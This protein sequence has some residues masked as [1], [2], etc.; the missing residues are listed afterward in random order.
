MRCLRSIRLW[1]AMFAGATAATGSAQ[2]TDYDIIVSGGTAP[3]EISW[4]LV[5]AFGN[6][7]TQG[8]APEN[9]GQ[10]LDD[11]CYTMYMYDD[12]GD[13]WNGATWSINFENTTISIASGTLTDGGWGAIQI[14]IGGVGCGGSG[15]TDQQI[16]VTAGTAPLDVYWEIYDQFN[17]FVWSGSAPE[18]IT[19]CLADGCYSMYLYDLTGDGWNGAEY[20]ITDVG[21]GTVQATGTL[22]SGGFATAQIIIGAGCGAC[23][24]YTMNVT[25]GSAPA[26]VSWEL[27]DASFT[28]I[29]AG[30]A[31]ENLSLC[32]PPGCYTIYMYDLIG[33][34]WNGA[35]YTFVN[36]A[37][38]TTEASGTLVNGSF[39]T[40]QVSIGGGC[41]SPTCSNFTMAVTGGSAPAQVSWNFMSM[42][43]NYGSGGAPNSVQMC[44]DTGCY[45]MQMYDAASN[46]W[47]GATWT[48]TNSLGATVGSGTLASGA[49]GSAAVNLGTGPCTVPTTVTASD[50]PQAVNVCTNLNFTIDPSGWGALW[51]IPALGSTGNPEFYVGDGIFS[52][53]GT[54]HYGC[55][56]GQEINTTWMIVN[57]SGSGSLEFTLGANGSQ[58]GF[59]DWTMFPYNATT[60][61]AIMANSLAPVRCNWNYASYGGTGLASTIPSGG[62]PENYETP[63]NVLAGQR[64]I[65]CFS[66]W[67]SVTTVVPLVF[68]GT[69]TVSCTPIVLPVELID[70]HA[71]PGPWSVELDW[72]TATE[73]NTSRFDVQRSADRLHW[74]TIGSVPASGNSASAISYR[75]SDPHPYEGDTYYRLAMIDQDAS[76]RLTP[77]VMA[78]WE[79]PMLHCWP[80]PTSGSF[81]IDLGERID[82]A[83]VQLMDHLGRAVSVHTCRSGDD[84]LL[85][86]MGDL[87]EGTYW[88]R[89][90]D[91]T[92]ERT[93]RIVRTRS[94]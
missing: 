17:N 10:C 56:M 57:I 6:T 4:E 18:N 52:P 36:D 41:S 1:L 44:L 7:V 39:G 33:N 29:A 53:W 24:G 5:D 79:A 75:L 14:D 89:V 72:T 82:R 3:D 34:G 25:S 78:H 42:G 26:D 59:Y 73:H 45:V 30:A 81:L 2:C 71:Q 60:C 48:L 43:V 87:P 84:E 28:F 31:P 20:T 19:L 88:I 38:G 54:D 92:W 16:V 94:H 35:N 62:V 8:N 51:E 68:G 70:F 66:N 46:G 69:A 15:C 63:L 9:D 13:G 86:D 47:N 90:S 65:I 11:G 83:N 55:L 23:D 37:S 40:A 58:T 74:A 50:C 91:G 76:E 67:S 93:G 85:I 22:N 77:W 80:N 27:Y 64:Y 21:T 12:G 32:L 49:N 61:G